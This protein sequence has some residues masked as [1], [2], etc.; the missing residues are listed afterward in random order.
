MNV[1]FLYQQAVAN[2]SFK[3]YQSLKEYFSKPLHLQSWDVLE[4][5]LLIEIHLVDHMIMNE[6]YSRVVIMKSC[7]PPFF[8]VSNMW[9]ADVSYDCGDVNACKK[10][11][12]FL[13]FQEPKNGCPNANDRFCLKDI[14]HMFVTVKAM[15]KKILTPQMANKHEQVCK[16]G[17]AVNRTC[18]AP[19]TQLPSW[20][21]TFPSKPNMMSVFCLGQI[22]VPCLLNSQISILDAP[23]VVFLQRG[24]N[25]IHVF[26]SS[27]VLLGDLSLFN[28]HSVGHLL[29]PVGSCSHWIDE[30][31][32]L[33]S[34]TSLIKL[35][36]FLITKNIPLPQ[37]RACIFSQHH[38]I[39]TFFSACHS[40]GIEITSI[41]N[42]NPN[43]FFQIPHL[44]P[45]EYQQP[46]SHNDQWLQPHLSHCHTPLHNHQLT[47]LQ[48]LKKNESNNQAMM[49]L[50]HHTD[51]DWIQRT[52]RQ[53]GRT[54]K[55]ST[56]V[57]PRGSILA[58]DMGLGKT[59]TTLMFIL[60]T[61]NLA[62]QSP[63]LFVL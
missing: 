49:A 9:A 42:Y 26:D 15:D 2:N 8:P 13:S 18:S 25:H 28:S 16:W 53:Q 12:I 37:L 44:S 7:Y 27:K 36:F 46:T 11:K 52:L 45:I 14:Q 58:D 22:I 39:T 56:E 57:Q 5:L 62:K 20:F 50:W 61:S 4:W 21:S 35:Q 47:A 54:S 38:D 24:T 23:Q 63:S 33:D 60:A 19:S 32:F 29:G 55:V 31:G 1:I 40:S 10:N 3:H 34:D 48:F 30:H 17:Q 41:W 43:L 6:M 59:L 51:N